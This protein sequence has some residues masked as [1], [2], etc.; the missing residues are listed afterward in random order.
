M[1]STWNMASGGIDLCLYRD[2]KIG[3]W[4]G[5]EVKHPLRYRAPKS[6]NIYV[7]LGFCPF[8]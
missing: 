2:T 6:G 3:P 5:S 4:V 1:Q 8:H 7:R